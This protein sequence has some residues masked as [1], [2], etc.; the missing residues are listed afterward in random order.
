MKHCCCH[1]DAMPTLAF[2]AHLVF[3]FNVGTF[4]PYVGTVGVEQGG[5]GGFVTSGAVTLHF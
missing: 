1:G 3:L 2:L 4:S 5:G